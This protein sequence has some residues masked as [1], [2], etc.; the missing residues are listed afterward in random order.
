MDY[1]FWEWEVEYAP[2]QLELRDAA[3][4]TIGIVM[5]FPAGS[6][7][8]SNKINDINAEIKSSVGDDYGLR[9]GYN[10]SDRSIRRLD[11][12][13]E[14]Y[15]PALDVVI[16]TADGTFPGPLN[17]GQQLGFDNFVTAT[18]GVAGTFREFYGA[19]ACPYKNFI[20]A[21]RDPVYTQS[22]SLSGTGPPVVVD[23]S[24]RKCHRIRYKY[25][26]GGLVF[27]E[28]LVESPARGRFR[29]IAGA[30]S[31]GN[32]PLENLWEIIR[33]GATARYCHRV[34][35]VPPESTVDFG[36]EYVPFGTAYTG[37]GRS[38][39]VYL[40]DPAVISDLHA[41]LEDA[42]EDFGSDAYHVNL[43][44]FSDDS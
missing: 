41:A 44:V 5:N 25:L 36:A 1:D 29:V 7:L 10:R 33:S 9:L 17:A 40:T 14:F 15:G 11:R 12:Y 42:T 37:A 18:D 4:D 31:S 24:R 38:T 13:V 8:P 2:L 6:D 21:R 39:E 28:R 23:R 32:A 16:M 34:P 43:E 22:M 26:P 35:A 3:N 30:S 20:A 27:R 19:F